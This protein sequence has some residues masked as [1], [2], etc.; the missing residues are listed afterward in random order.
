ML[1]TVI[2]VKCP[3][4]MKC[5]GRAKRLKKKYAKDWNEVSEEERNRRAKEIRDLRAMYTKLPRYEARDTN[6]KKI[7]YTR[8]C[9]DF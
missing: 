6:F 2:D 4:N 9:D 7:Q 5:K 3:M 8:Y 1:E